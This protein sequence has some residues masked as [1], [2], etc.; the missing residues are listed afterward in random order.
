M[1]YKS[2]LTGRLGAVGFTLIELLVVVLIIG[3]LSAVALPKYQKAIERSR[4]AEAMTVLRSLAQASDAYYLATGTYPTTFD[5]LP[6]TL[7]AYTG[8]QQ[9]AITGDGLK[10]TR[11]NGYWSLQMWVV[12]NQDPNSANYGRQRCM[13]MSPWKGKYKYNSLGWC[14]ERDDNW[15]PVRQLVCYERNVAHRGDYCQQVMKGTPLSSNE[16]AYAL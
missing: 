14:L 3:I 6:V 12:N 16:H 5:E 11:S 7:P 2:R 15:F 4:A 10:D 8:H 9:T 13:Y 1:F